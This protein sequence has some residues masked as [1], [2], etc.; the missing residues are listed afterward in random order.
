M[1][2]VLMIIVIVTPPSSFSFSKPL[3]PANPH[4]GFI[5][6]NFNRF[7]PDLMVNGVILW[8][9]STGGSVLSHS[10]TPI[11]SGLS[12]KERKVIRT[13]CPV[14]P[15]A[16]FHGRTKASIRRSKPETFDWTWNLRTS[17]DR[18]NAF[19]CVCA[20]VQGSHLPPVHRAGVQSL[21]GDLR[22]A[23]QPG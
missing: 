7:K 4:C 1:S 9:V 21:R 2:V 12:T 20:C 15:G 5:C 22:S 17:H 10:S 11:H 23:E 6:G 14:Y 19:L 3:T 16:L 18:F 13:S 8:R